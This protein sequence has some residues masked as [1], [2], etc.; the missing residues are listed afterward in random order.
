MIPL[1]RYPLAVVAG[2]IIGE[3]LSIP[4]AALLDLMFGANV[5]GGRWPLTTANVILVCVKGLITGYSAG[6]IARK[7]GKIIGGLADLLPLLLVFVT[8]IVMNR[9][10]TYYTYTDTRPALWVY[11]GLLP[12]VAGGHLGVKYGSKGLSKTGLGWHWLWFLPLCAVVLSLIERHLVTYAFAIVKLGYQ[13]WSW[14][15]LLSLSAD[16]CLS[17]ILISVRWPLLGLLFLAF[18]VKAGNQLKASQRWVYSVLLIGGISV[19]PLVV[20]VLVWGSF[21][22]II[23]GQGISRLRMIPFIPWPSGHYGEY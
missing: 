7:Y 22:F 14:G 1:V 15:A 23:D 6:W 4:V 5:T 13:R 16:F 21:P 11:I 9:D 20:E 12:A 17:L 10:L 18:L 19:S 3:V 8:S 2:A